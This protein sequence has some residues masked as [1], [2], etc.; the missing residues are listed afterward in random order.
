MA[1]LASSESLCKIPPVSEVEIESSDAN[2]RS[3]EPTAAHPRNEAAPT[4]PV[5]PQAPSDDPSQK[6]PLSQRKIEANRQNSSASTG[7]KTLEGKRNSSRNA[8]KHGLFAPE[9]VNVAQGES[10][11]RFRRLLQDL[12]NEYEPVGR[13]EGIL[14]EK[15]AACLWRQARIF[16]AEKGESYVEMNAVARAHLSNKLQQFNSALRR[17]KTMRLNRYIKGD[18]NTLLTFPSEQETIQL[19]TGTS[20]GMDFVIS[21]LRE[22]KV[23][24]EKKGSLTL[25]TR[26]LLMDCLGADWPD[27]LPEN[28]REGQSLDQSELRTFL[29]ILD[30]EMSSLSLLQG[31][32]ANMEGRELEAEMQRH[33]LP[34]GAATDKLI[35]SEAH[36]ER[37]LNRAMAELDRLQMRRRG[38]NGPPEVR[39]HL[40]REV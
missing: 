40:T 14:V 26:R 10:P 35:R 30:H 28:I 20:R 32:N 24:V 11:E 19:L 4:H 38:E 12:W 36:F 2:V 33:N 15:I 27:E 31:Y 7:P 9:V 6:P 21:K 17:W 22:V 16:R 18:Q 3:N 5:N 37:Q 1:T 13:T 29:E 39:V 34:S 23:D 8:L 25:A